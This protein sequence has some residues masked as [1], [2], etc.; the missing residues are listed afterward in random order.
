MK[1]NE[2]EMRMNLPLILMNEC[3]VRVLYRVRKVDT[4]ERKEARKKG[5][6]F[7][8]AVGC[9]SSLHV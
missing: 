3:I 5:R 8:G 7:V 4:K 6:E 9:M 2:R 1:R